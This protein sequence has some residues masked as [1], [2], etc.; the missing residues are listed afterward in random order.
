[1]QYHVSNVTITGFLFDFAFLI[2]SFIDVGIRVPGQVK[3]YRTFGNLFLTQK[4]FYHL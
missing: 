4:Y 2:V 3:K 1:M